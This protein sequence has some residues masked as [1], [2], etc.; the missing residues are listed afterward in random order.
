MES[1]E[2]RNTVEFRRKCGVI[3]SFC[4]LSICVIGMEFSCTTMDHIYYCW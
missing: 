1:E 2:R 3:V 4:F